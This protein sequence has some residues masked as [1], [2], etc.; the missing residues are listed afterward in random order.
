M[1]L[2]YVDEFRDGAR[3]MEQLA[4][5]RAGVSRRWVVMD[6]CGGQTHAFLKYGLEAAV[7]DVLELIHGPGCP[8]C[9]TPA[10]TLDQAVELAHRP[11]MMLTSYGDMLRVPSSRG[12]LLQARARGASLRT[13]YSPVDAVTLAKEHPETQVVFLAV[14]F[15]TTAPATAL[16]LLQARQ[17]GLRNFSVLAHHV[18]VEPAMRAL[19]DQPDCRVQA[20]LAAGHVCTVTG[21]AQYQDLV[22]RYQI[23]VVVTGFEPVDLLAGL[24]EC[25]RQLESRQPRLAN[26]YARCARPEGNPQARQWIGEVFEIQTIP[27]RGLGAIPEGGLVIRPE[28]GDFDARRR[29]GLAEVV[30]ETRDDDAECQSALVLAGRIKPAACPLFGTTCRPDQPRG[31]PMVSS[32]GACAAYYQYSIAGEFPDDG[33]ARV[34]LPAPRDGLRSDHAGSR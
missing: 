4:R 3:V 34:S 6:V 2:R 28:F 17:T 13:V 19:L 18:R 22:N 31:A 23:P 20:F 5:L 15:E 21:Y 14:G 24:Q 33:P 30:A 8:V 26:C 16:A 9:V 1:T 12:S 10:E 11:G 25:V 27:W 7:E 32:E 29:F